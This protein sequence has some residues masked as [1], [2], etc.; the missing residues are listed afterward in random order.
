MIDSV[1]FDDADRHDSV[2]W[3]NSINE[4]LSLDFNFDE[5]GATAF[6]FAWMLD[7]SSRIPN[8][9]VQKLFELCMLL[10]NLYPTE[11]NNDKPMPQIY[12]FLHDM[13]RD[14]KQRPKNSDDESDD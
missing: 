13:Y 8:S 7:K 4:I 6:I 5:E 3:S 9:K 11:G 14:P 12:V 1:G 2:N 10:T